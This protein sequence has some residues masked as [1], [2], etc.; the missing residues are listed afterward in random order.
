M[1]YKMIVRGL[2]VAALAAT[3]FAGTAMA[4]FTAPTGLAPGSKYQIFFVTSDGTTATSLNIADYNA[5]VQYEAG[6]DPMLP[7]ATWT[8]VASTPTFDAINASPTTNY[9]IYD[10]RGDLLEPG[11]LELFTDGSFGGPDYD[12]NG[13]AVIADT[14]VWTGSYSS[15]LSYTDYALGSSL[16]TA[17]GEIDGPYDWFCSGANYIEDLFPLYAVSTPI[18]VASVPEPAT[19]TLLG[20]ALLGLGVVYLRRRRAKA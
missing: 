3:M 4:G 16:Y 14:Q 15:G 19:L 7:S 17:E 1:S 20:S 8:A 11:F 9:P 6:L 12:Q 10:T 13:K 2:S 18:T 5:F